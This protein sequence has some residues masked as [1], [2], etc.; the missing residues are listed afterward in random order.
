MALQRLL[1]FQMTFGC[2]LFKKMYVQ[3]PSISMCTH[4]FLYYLLYPHSGPLNLGLLLPFYRWENWGPEGLKSWTVYGQQVLG[5]E[6]SR[7]FLPYKPCV[8]SVVL[9]AG[10]NRD[11]V[12]SGSFVQIENHRMWFIFFAL[13]LGPKKWISLS[14]FL[15]HKFRA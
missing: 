6:S 5:L 14:V 12:I 9:K 10:V 7:R 11:W 3:G 15:I 8:P 1:E 2:V 4:F 13:F